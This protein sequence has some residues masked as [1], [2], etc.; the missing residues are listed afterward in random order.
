VSRRRGEPESL[1]ALAARFWSKVGIVIGADGQPDRAACWPW[2]AAFSIRGSRLTMNGKYK[3]GIF[4]LRGRVVLAHRLAKALA[5]DGVMPEGMDGAHSCDNPICCNPD[6]VEWK[7]RAANL[8][9]HAD[10]HGWIGAPKL[11]PARAVSVLEKG[12]S[13][14][15]Y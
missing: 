10:R 5:T 3:R 14:G 2:R 11:S 1:E 9:D 6:H 8:A 12:A 15:V 13:D 7:T 4:K